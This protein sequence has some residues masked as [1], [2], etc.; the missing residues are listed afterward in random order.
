MQ[1]SPILTPHILPR[2]RGGAGH[3]P[4]YP[5]RVARHPV[6]VALLCSFAVGCQR[7]DLDRGAVTTTTTTSARPASTATTSRTIDNA[8]Y[9]D[10]GGRT[11]E[12][13]NRTEMSGMRATEVGS[14]RPTGTPGSGTPIPGQPRRAPEPERGAA[15]ATAAVPGNGPPL[16]DDDVAR[17]ARAR[18]DRATSCGRVGAGR[19]FETDSDCMMQQRGRGQD[20]LGAVSC[21]GGIDHRQLGLC[22]AELRKVACGASD[23]LDATPSCRATAICVE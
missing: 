1:P 23:A 12:M 2:A 7:S 11:S 5:R 3:E 20:D 16:L 10:N 19:A 14:E 4:C 8:G 22:L 17:L 18:C 6:T 9:V 13:T 15:A 21:A